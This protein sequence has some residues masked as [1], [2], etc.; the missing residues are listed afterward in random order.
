MKKIN[1]LVMILLLAIIVTACSLSSTSLTGT[2][3]NLKLEDLNY[4][5]DNL[6]KNHKNLYANIFYPDIYVEQNFENYLNG[7]D[8]EIE[9]IL[10][11]K[12]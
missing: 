2:E 7:I 11:I 12:E 8:S 4:F 3:L 9:M 6:E 10:K 5:C 1:Y